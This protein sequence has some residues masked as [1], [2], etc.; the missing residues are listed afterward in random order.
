MMGSIF[1]FLI[2][3]IL[4][5]QWIGQGLLEENWIP[6]GKLILGLLFIAWSYEGVKK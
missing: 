2:G 5:L 6:L 3:S 1:P 4:L